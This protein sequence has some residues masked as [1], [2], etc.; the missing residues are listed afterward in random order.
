M[1]ETDGFKRMRKTG[2]AEA[3]QVIAVA[4]DILLNAFAGA[5]V[6]LFP[7]LSEALKK[8]DED[9]WEEVRDDGMKLAQTQRRLSW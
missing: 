5:V 6:P 3:D 4:W 9:M 2:N 8:W 7:E 1:E